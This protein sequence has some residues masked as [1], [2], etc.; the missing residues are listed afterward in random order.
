ME[1]HEVGWRGPWQ[2]LEGTEARGSGVLDK[3][4]GCREQGPQ[5]ASGPQEELW[6]R[7]SCELLLTPYVSSRLLLGAGVPAHVDVSQVPFTYIQ[8]SRTPTP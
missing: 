7:N 5:H 2:V 1:G 3:H 6:P 4:S 8:R